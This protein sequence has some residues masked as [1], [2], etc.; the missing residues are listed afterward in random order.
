MSNFETEKSVFLASLETGNCSFAD[1]MTF[2]ENWFDF[3]PSAFING[4]VQNQDN[5]N[6]GSCKILAL[7]SLLNL[8]EQQTLSCFGE[9]YSDVL[10]TPEGTDHQNIRQFMQHGWKGVTLEP[11]PMAKR[12]S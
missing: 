7:G 10:N 12:T 4:A 2:I 11:I 8:S 6:Q 3:T 9:Y 5:E 1:T